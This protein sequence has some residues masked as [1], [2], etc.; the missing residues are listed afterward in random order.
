MQI[1]AGHLLLS[2][3]DLVNFLGCRHATYLDLRDLADPVELPQRDAAT[4][5]I[6]E[7]EIEHEKRHLVSLKAAEIVGREKVVA[8]TDY[9]LGGRVHADLA[10]AKLRSLGE[11]ARLASNSL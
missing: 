7:K 9:R 2:A 10:W 4:V 1:L 8:G 6:F 3:T 11:G 5:L